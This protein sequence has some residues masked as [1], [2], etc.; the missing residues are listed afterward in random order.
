MV[1]FNYYN[2]S[3]INIKNQDIKYS[4]WQNYDVNKIA[5]QRGYILAHNWNSKIK[6]NEKSDTTNAPTKPA[7]QT[8][9]KTLLLN[10]NEVIKSKINHTNDAIDSHNKARVRCVLF[11]WIAI[12][13]IKIAKD[14]II[15][16]DTIR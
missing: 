12:K 6:R 4:F 5:Y 3:A 11:S 14:K 8:N 1:L 13:P 7:R 2:S 10:E 9:N 16:T 15:P